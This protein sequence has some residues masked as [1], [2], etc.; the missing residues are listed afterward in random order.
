MLWFW[1]PVIAWLAVLAVESTEWLSS[2]H[3]GRILYWLLVQV[4]GHAGGPMVHVMNF[5]LRKFGHFVGYGILCLLIFRALRNTW[6]GTL[7]RW[8]LLSITITA[9][10]AS[11]D[12]WHQTFLPSRTGRV[13]DVVLDTV[14]A[15]CLQAIGLALI[16]ARRQNNARLHP[17]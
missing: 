10:I 4:F 11:L 14:G 8:T 15:I 6:Q 13:R 5:V 7:V 16:Y 1:L 3:T 17:G 9:V 12:E 2:E